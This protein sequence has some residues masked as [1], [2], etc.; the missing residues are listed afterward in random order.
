MTLMKLTMGYE[1]FA[2][3]E[4]VCTC[5]QCPTGAARQY[6]ITMSG[7]VDNACV[8]CGELNNTFRVTYNSNCSWNGSLGST[9]CFPSV[10]TISLFYLSDWQI[11]IGNDELT[12][13]VSPF[14]CK[15]GADFTS[16]SIIGAQCQ[17]SGVTV[18]IEPVAP[19]GT[20]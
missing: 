19:V 4:L 15:E 6:D 7:W 10:P 20:C 17:T 9:A 12:I 8:G 2:T 13:A 1:F 18:A 14:D 5:I 11:V 3:S 16:G